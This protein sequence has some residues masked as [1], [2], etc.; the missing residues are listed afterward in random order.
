VLLHERELFLESADA[1]G[2]GFGL[3]DVEGEE[4]VVVPVTSGQHDRVVQELVG[5]REEGFP[6]VC[7]EGEFISVLCNRE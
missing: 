7:S 5:S 2:F 3:E 4:V 6:A 1:D